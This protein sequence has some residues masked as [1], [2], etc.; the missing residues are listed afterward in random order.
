MDIETL[1]RGAGLAV[2]D[3][4]TPEQPLGDGLGVGIGQHDP[5]I[6]AAQLQRE[7]L[8][9]L[10]GRHHHLL[11]GVNR[12]G[13][14]DLGDVWMGRHQGTEILGPVIA[15]GDHI[16]HTGRQDFVHQLDQPDC[17]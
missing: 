8:H 6:V 10:G 11:A 15:G 9:R 4:P 3:E 12:A 7:P 14:H 1:H 2:I 17:G 16:D 5:G 13:Q